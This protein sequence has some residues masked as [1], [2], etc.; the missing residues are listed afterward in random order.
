MF[1]NSPYKTKTEEEVLKVVENLK[2]KGYKLLKNKN[3]NGDFNHLQNFFIW[4]KTPNHFLRL[5]LISEGWHE[6]KVFYWSLDFNF[7]PFNKKK[8]DKW[9]S[10]KFKGTAEDLYLIRFYEAI[11]QIKLYLKNKVVTT[12]QAQVNKR[13][14]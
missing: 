10:E 2:F 7:I 1:D 8:C 3:S 5:C 11:K 14:L 12:R 4:E 13:T 6:E 9:R